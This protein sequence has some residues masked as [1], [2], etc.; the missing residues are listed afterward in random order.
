MLK[1]L[2]VWFG[3]VATGGEAEVRQSFLGVS[4]IE[5]KFCTA[6]GITEQLMKEQNTGQASS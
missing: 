1:F 3:L 4:R 2:R 5:S 6:K